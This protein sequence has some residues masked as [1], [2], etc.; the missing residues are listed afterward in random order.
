MAGTETVFQVNDFFMGL[1]LVAFKSELT[2]TH[3]GYRP[4]VQLRWVDVGQELLLIF[5]NVHGLR[6]SKG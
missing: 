6:P 5:W 2:L 4:S 3:I 1:I